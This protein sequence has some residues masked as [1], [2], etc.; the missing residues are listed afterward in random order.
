MENDSNT[1]VK[2]PNITVKL[3]GEDGN[4]FAVLGAVK[5]ALRKANIPQ[6]E[7]NGFFAEATTG[8]YDNL[9][10]VC[11]AWVNVE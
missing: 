11:M 10:R 1:K 4:A 3:I 6:E 5:K 2:Y 9:L 8:D 7:I